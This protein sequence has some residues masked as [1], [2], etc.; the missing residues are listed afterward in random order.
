MPLH[1][2]A[3]ATLAEVK[4]AL[5]E[6]TTDNDALYTN[7]INRATDI[8]EKYCNSRRFLTTS[9]RNEIYDGTGTCYLNLRHYPITAI[10]SLEKRT[11]DFASPS[12]D[13]IDTAFYTYTD[14]TTHGPGQ[15]YY[16]GGFALGALNYRVTYDAGYATIPTDLTQAC[17]ALVT[18]LK[19]MT[20]SPGLK[21][22]TLAE[23]SYTKEDVGNMIKDLGLD[24][25]LDFYRTPV[26]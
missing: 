20:R 23:Y 1:A 11:G 5:S 19:T 8:I 13:A 14:D 9:Y 6:T 21:S 16:S 15:V 18:Y 22:E 2:Y 3:L 10:T 12:W 17:I 26:C 24:L 25:I 7:L 4:E